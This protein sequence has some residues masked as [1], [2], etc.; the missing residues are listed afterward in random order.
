MTKARAANRTAEYPVFMIFASASAAAPKLATMTGGRDERE[1]RVIEEE[2]QVGG[3]D[4]VGRDRGHAHAEDT[5]HHDGQQRDEDVAVREV[6]QLAR[7]GTN[8]PGCGDPGVNCRKIWRQERPAAKPCARRPLRSTMRTA[9]RATRLSP[10]NAVEPPWRPAR[11]RRGLERDLR[12]FM[13]AHADG[14]GVR[15]LRAR[16]PIDFRYR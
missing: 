8:A 14:G 2:E 11:A 10:V 1:H 4:D 16:G 6:D 5:G 12:A 13:S 9:C 15:A 3:R 7:T